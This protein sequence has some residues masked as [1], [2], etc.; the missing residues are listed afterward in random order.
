VRGKGRRWKEL[1]KTR[2][3]KA[4]RRVSR[5][6]KRKRRRTLVRRRTTG[7][8]GVGRLIPF[9]R[10]HVYRREGV[11]RADFV[12]RNVSIHNGH[13]WFTVLIRPSMVGS[14]FGEYAPPKQWRGSMIH[15]GNKTEVKKNKKISNLKAKKGKGV[16]K[17]AKKG[18]TAKGGAKGSKAA[19]AKKGAKGS[20]AKGAPKSA[21]KGATA[22]GGAGKK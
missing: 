2:A 9:C 6:L 8:F 20:P 13:R 15:R 17:G 16:A 11:I 12:G 3:S 22:K 5:R 10:W 1:I 7:E 4:V 21:K 18:A 19:G 14:R